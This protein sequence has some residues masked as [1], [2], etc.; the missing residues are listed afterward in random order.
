MA[1]GAL[2]AVAGERAGAALGGD[3]DAGRGDRAVHRQDRHA[4]GEPHARARASTPAR[5]RAAACGGA[6]RE[7]PRGPPPR[8]SR[9][10]CS[11]P[12]ATPSTRWT[13]L[14]R[15]RPRHARGDRDC[16]RDWPLRP[17]VRPPP[18][19]ARDHAGVAAR[20]R[21]PAS[22]PPR[23]RRKRWPTC[24]ASTAASAPRRCRRR[25]GWPREGLRVLAVA[26]RPSRRRRPA[27]PRRTTSL[28]VRWA[29]RL[30]RSAARRRA[31]GGGACRRAGIR[32]AMITGD[33]PATARAIAREAG[34]DAEARADRQR[35]RRAWTTPRSPSACAARGVRPHPARSR[36]CASCRPSG[37]AARWSR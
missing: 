22:S 9:P 32:V 6:E 15:A 1:I 37:R 29:G 21:G 18:G 3:R 12:R 23:A 27:R 31:G 30:R 19:P 20:R 11:P 33:Y 35:A 28:R 36:S 26:E 10:A 5:E 7:L 2:A 8:C 16:T 13:G 25:A 34:I 4:D 14:Q 24:A 17:R